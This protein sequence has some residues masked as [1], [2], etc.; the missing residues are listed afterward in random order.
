[1][2]H[3][4]ASRMHRMALDLLELARMDAGIADFKRQ[5]VDLANLL[6]SLV[7]KFAP[8]AHQAQ[9][10]LELQID[11]LPSIFGDEDHLTQVFTNLVD[12]ALKYSPTGG[13]VRLHAQQTGPQVEISISDTGAGIPPDEL[14]RIFERFYQTDKA[15]SSGRRGVGLGLTI[16]REIVLAHGGRLNVRSN[17]GQGSTFTVTL[18]T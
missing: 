10:N 16:A 12:N 5:P 14:P 1:V 18:P 7:E 9:V 15:R 8:Q 4:E 11:P 6:R 2:I 3:D 17:P 13:Q